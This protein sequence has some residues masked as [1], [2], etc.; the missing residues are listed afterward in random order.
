[1]SRPTTCQTNP[2]PLARELIETLVAE[3]GR[4][5]LGYA[6]RLTGDRS[7]AEDVV[8]E[9]LARAWTH[10]ETLLQ[11]DRRQRAWLLT[12]VRN[13][14]IDQA[15]ARKARPPIVSTPPPDDVIGA[16]AARGRFQEARAL[17]DPADGV[18]DRI[19]VVDLL[20]R[21]SPVHRE[22]LVL[23]YFGDLT[24]NQA[25]ERLGIPPGTVKSRAFY[26]LSAL[27]QAVRDEGVDLTA[28]VNQ[29]NA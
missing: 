1:M 2:E 21:L 13:I 17:Q 19:T 11:L 28:M 10:R 8:Q 22:V 25:A 29:V 4:A 18:V 20:A 12:V 6:T 14:V 16:V 23:L 15:R 24:V 3:H 9:A 26:A 7:Q 5:I 27:R